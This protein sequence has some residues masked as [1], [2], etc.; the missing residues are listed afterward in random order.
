[1]I[2][3]RADTNFKQFTYLVGSFAAL[4]YDSPVGADLA[5]AP[6]LVGLT[7]F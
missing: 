4:L 3:C 2:T 7:T 1:M 6:A 5:C